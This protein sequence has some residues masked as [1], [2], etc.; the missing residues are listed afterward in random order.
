MPVRK[1]TLQRTDVDLHVVAEEITRQTL[2]L[3][4]PGGGPHKNLTIRPDVVEDLADL[5]LEAH[6]QH[7]IG[8]VQHQ[9]RYP[10]Q[11]RG[12]GLEEIDQ[13]TGRGDHDLDAA[14]QIR[15]LRS[16]A[17]ATEQ[18]RVANVR[19]RAELGRDLLDL[20]RQLAGRGQHEHQR[21]AHGRVRLLVINVHDRGQHVGERFARTGLGDADH[22]QSAERDRPALRLDRRRAL[23][24][25]PVDLPLDVVGY[26]DLVELG[27]RFRAL[28]DQRDI[29]LSQV[30]IHLLLGAI[31]HDRV[32]VVEIFLERGQRHLAPIDLGHPAG[33]RPLIAV[34]AAS[35]TA[36][37]E[38][39]TA[40]SIAA[41]AAT[42]T[43]S[44][45]TTTTGARTGRSSSAL[46][47]GPGAL[48]TV[49]RRWCGGSFAKNGWS[50]ASI[51]VMRSFGSYSSIF[52][53]RSN[54]CMCS[55]ASDMALRI[56]G[57]QFCST[58]RASDVFSSQSSLPCGKY[59]VGVFFAMWYGIGPSMRSIMARCSRLSCV[60]N[61]VMPRYS[62]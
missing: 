36:P 9:V 34:P 62:S 58:Y 56:S 7:A 46:E 57:L 49:V 6:V 27:D 22:V 61:S 4:G 12:A 16:L 38:A 39:T 51:S 44:T 1:H 50:S 45:V 23:V 21:T 52:A 15:R 26:F 48:H 54:I 33:I 20:L 13:P 60:W 8:L 37:T 55:G 47:L 25:L 59:R 18:A 43:T 14:A 29:V 32:L 31:A 19:R 5:R 17:R 2:H 42:T 40:A 41:G 3:L 35:C 30:A 11:G 24:P 53:I 10:L 28:A